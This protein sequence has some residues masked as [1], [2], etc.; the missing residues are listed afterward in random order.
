M[1]RP[2]GAKLTIVDIGDAARH[3]GKTAKNLTRLIDESMQKSPNDWP[4]STPV[5]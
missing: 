4:K 1:Q 5:L 2:F 3:P